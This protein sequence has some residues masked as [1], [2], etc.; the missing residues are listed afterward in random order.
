[1]T[2][3]NSNLSAVNFTELLGGTGPF[4]LSAYYSNGSYAQGISGV[5]TS[6][7]ISYDMF[8][9]KTKNLTFGTYAR[10]GITLNTFTAVG[11]TGYTIPTTGYWLMECIGGGGGGGNQ[12]SG[13]VA[14]G[15]GGGGAY[16]SGISYISSGTSVNVTVGGGGA[17]VSNG[18]LWANGTSGNP[19]Y[20]SIGGTEM[21]RANGGGGGLGASSSAGGTGGTATVHASVGRAVAFTGGNGGNAYLNVNEAH[22]GGAGGTSGNANGNGI[23]G[24]T[25]NTSSGGATAQT[26]IITT[27]AG[28]RGYFYYVPWGVGAVVQATNGQGY[29]AGGGGGHDSAS[30]TGF[31]G[32]VRMTLLSFP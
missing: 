11:T 29:G 12:Y 31:Q 9:G 24:V 15:G 19:S 2:L 13:W 32:V 4:M 1:M 27:G 22:S 28:G 30:G 7:M 5:P 18:T 14:G 21:M 8:R 23:S 26:G 16:T 25:T 6:G 20:I 17:N 3:P 10:S